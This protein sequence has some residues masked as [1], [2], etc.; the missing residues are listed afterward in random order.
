MDGTCL[1][2][3]DQDDIEAMIPGKNSVFSDT[4]HYYKT[5]NLYKFSREFSRTHY[6][7]FLEAYQKHWEIMNTMTQG[8]K[9]YQ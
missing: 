4:E 1:V 8:I 3:S 9:G 7:P 6:V 2:L 5:V